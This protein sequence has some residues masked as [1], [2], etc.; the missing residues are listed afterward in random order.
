MLLF[1][2]LS[3]IVALLVG[4]LVYYYSKKVLAGLILVIILGFLFPVFLT[5]SS[6]LLFSV[7]INIL[8]YFVLILIVKKRY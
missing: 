7:L 8:L 4:Y 3:I 5:D 6:F 1:R 2:V